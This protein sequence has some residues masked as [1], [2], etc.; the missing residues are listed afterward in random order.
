MKHETMKRRLANTHTKSA[1]FDR[2]GVVIVL[3]RG[4]AST[5][6]GVAMP[7][8]LDD[9]T[10]QLA[11]FTGVVADASFLEALSVEWPRLEEE[12]ITLIKELLLEIVMEAN[13]VV[14]AEELVDAHSG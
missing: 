14:S 5:K 13:G 7:L 4:E 6:M 12:A 10:M 11:R 8:N 2:E 3:S 1:W 9:V